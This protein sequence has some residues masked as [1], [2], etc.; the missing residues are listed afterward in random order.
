MDTVGTFETVSYPGEPEEVVLAWT[1]VDGR[2]LAGTNDGRL[3]RCESDRTWTEEGRVAAGIRS[4][5]IL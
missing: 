1:A 4:L 2:V 5:T 3:I